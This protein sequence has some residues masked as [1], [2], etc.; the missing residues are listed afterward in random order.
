MTS[1]PLAAVAPRVL[2]IR[3][4]RT[5][6]IG[7]FGPWLRAAG[8]ELVELAADEGEVVP[9]AVPAGIDAVIALGGEQSATDDEIAP[10]QPAERA[11]LLDAI[12]RE[13]PLLGICL[14]AQLMTVAMGGQ[15]QPTLT[16]EVGLTALQLSDA[17]ATDPLFRTLPAGA[18]A[19]QYHRDEMVTVPD[20]AVVLAS[21]ER[22]RH[23]AWRL[24]QHAWAV[25]F[26]P[27]AGAQTLASWLQ[28][29][30][31]IEQRLGVI[32]AAV[33][34]AA[35]QQQAELTRVW[36]SFATTFAAIVHAAVGPRSD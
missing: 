8:L 10:W 33:V 14:G 3:N 18:P 5:D 31:Q 13:V 7:V 6:P 21:T 34:S 16:P 27:E 17:A 24:G 26:H 1:N 28:S 29:D 36:S 25:Q 4:D 23:Q 19:P 12:N 20:G 15:V 2:V 9:T 32:P 30:P 11:L 22:C 35:E